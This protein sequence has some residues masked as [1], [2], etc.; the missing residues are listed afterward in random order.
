MT[1]IYSVAYAEHLKFQPEPVSA[2]TKKE[3]E[4]VLEQPL[5]DTWRTGA[6]TVAVVDGWAED[7][8]DRTRAILKATDDVKEGR[9]VELAIVAV[10]LQNET[11]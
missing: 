10:A 4:K 7:A 2:A 1:R 3:P 11:E 8:I 9:V 6:K 5:V